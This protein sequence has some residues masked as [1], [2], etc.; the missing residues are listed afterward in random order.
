[1]MSSIQIDAEQCKKCGTCV[2]ICPADLF[3][4]EA[5]GTVPKII[6]TA[7][8][9]DCGHCVAICPNEA[10]S[11]SS[12]P[13]GSIHPVHSEMLPNTEQLMELLRSRRSIR[14]FRNKP[15]E[16]A[17][18]EQVIEGAR[19]A[20]SAHNVQS[21]EFIVIQDKAVLSQILKITVAQ[22]NLWS[23]ILKNPLLRLYNR[24]VTHTNLDEL[25]KSFTKIVCEY[26]QGKDLVL[27]DAPTLLLFHADKN[28]GFAS[29]NANLALQ[30]AS[31]VCET[32]GL[33][34]FYTGFVIF[35]CDFNKQIA[36]MLELPPQHKI[37]GGLA[38]GYPKFRYHNWIER[39][40]AHI[41][42]L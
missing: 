15:V 6:D 27:H 29:T 38:I 3:V 17:A 10:I 32:L 21:T 40:P 22:L 37:Y 41:K 33:G 1:M 34:A 4:Q 42:W 19:F 30:N 2:Q 23:K 14:E 24:F 16:Q 5:K 9:L 13:S 11:H 12:F 8:C 35:A 25:V 26:E 39:H 36:K 18:I 31:L 20:P 7:N 28:A